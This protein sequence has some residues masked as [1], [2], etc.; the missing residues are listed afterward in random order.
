MLRWRRLFER[1]EDGMGLKEGLVNV[2]WA[3][4]CCGG[5]EIG[6]AVGVWVLLWEMWFVEVVV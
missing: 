3:W 4:V 1:V 5:V 6:G 2:V